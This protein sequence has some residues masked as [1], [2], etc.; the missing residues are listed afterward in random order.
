VTG[1]RAVIAED[2][3][4]A[5]VARGAQAARGFEGLSRFAGGRFHNF[6]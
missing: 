1:W 4:F 2:V 3:N 6:F 5:E